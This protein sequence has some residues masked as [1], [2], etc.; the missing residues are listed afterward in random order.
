MAILI[1]RVSNLRLRCVDRDLLQLGKTVVD[2]WM[3]EAAAASVRRHKMVQIVVRQDQA[4]SIAVFNNWRLIS[5]RSLYI[6]VGLQRM[7]LR[8][9]RALVID[10]ILEWRREKLLSKRERLVEW[11]H[12]L[13][14]VSLEQRVLRAIKEHTKLAWA[15][16]HLVQRMMVRDM[17]RCTGSALHT[18]KRRWELEEVSRRSKLVAQQHHA[19]IGR[20][21][22]RMSSDQISVVSETP[23]K[24]DPEL[25]AVPPSAR[26]TGVHVI[27]HRDSRDVSGTGVHVSRAVTPPTF[28]LS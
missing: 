4:Q 13:G 1:R 2:A 17:R 7:Q 9:E 5:A 10:V 23:A 22:A 26:S 21:Q 8:R 11:K 19:W 16:K 27:Q 14:Q 6:R 3:E 24:G 12:R 28:P 20:W 25:Y 15:R 18:W